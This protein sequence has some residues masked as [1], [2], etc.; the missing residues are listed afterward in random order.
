MN[1]MVQGTAEESTSAFELHAKCAH[2]ADKAV[3]YNHAAMAEFTRVFWETLTDSDDANEHKPGLN[4]M[5]SIEKDFDSVDNLREEFLETADALFGN[6]F[7]WLMKAPR[8]GELTIL[9]TYNAG[10]PYSEAAPRRDNR[11]M[12]TYDGSQIAAQ[13][14]GRSGLGTPSIEE[15]ALSRS[16]AGSFGPLSSAR[17]NL[18]L[19]ALDAQPILCVN[20]WQHQWLPDWGI[21]G[22]RAYL[23]AWWDSIDWQ[24]VERRHC[25]YSLDGEADRYIPRNPYQQGSVYEAIRRQLS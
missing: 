1:E 6:G 13:L 3:L 11:D 14:S 24:K 7:V 9:A 19:G 8:T 17:A 25:D 15:R 16:T 22:K 5:R 2:R 18:Y 4:T 12:A 10:S 23:R 21:L 20:V